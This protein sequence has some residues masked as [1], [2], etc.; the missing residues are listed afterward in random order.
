MVN[1]SLKRFN[2]KT[3]DKTES[4]YTRRKMPGIGHR[5]IKLNFTPKRVSD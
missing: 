2:Y 5:K 1:D 3:N 4:R